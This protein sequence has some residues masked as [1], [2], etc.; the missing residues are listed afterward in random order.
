MR[1]FLHAAYAAN[2]GAEV[3]ICRSVKDVVVV[4]A[5]LVESIS[6]KKLCIAFER[7]KGFRWI[8]VIASAMATS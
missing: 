4:A 3:I 6:L 1:M 2:H 5:S 7:G 8:H